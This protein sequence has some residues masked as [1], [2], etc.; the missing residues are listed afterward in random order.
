MLIQIFLGCLLIVVTTV[1]HA[2]GMVLSFGALRVVH[3]QSWAHRSP[4]T[5]VVAVSSLVLLLFL[6]TF[7]ESFIWAVVYV[8]VGALPDLN[9]ALY[10]SVITF[11]SVG[12]G[13]IVLGGEW[14]HLAG[15]EAAN[16]TIMFGWTTALIFAGVQRVYFPRRNG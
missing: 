9:D 8:G 13:D 14:R 5:Q 7:I 12:F 6:V 16:G 1:V 15:I 3:V 2:S 4:L 10:F 11:T